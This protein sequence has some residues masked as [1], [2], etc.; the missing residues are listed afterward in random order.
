MWNSGVISTGAML[1]PPLPSRR[2]E[3]A[4]HQSKIPLGL[5]I[6]AMALDIDQKDG[7]LEVVNFG[8]QVHLL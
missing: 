5:V 4:G 1:S 8:A 7:G 6:Q 3:C 2:F